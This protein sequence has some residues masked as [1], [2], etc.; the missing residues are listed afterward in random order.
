ME[1]ETPEI[2]MRDELLKKGKIPI[3]RM[4]E[5]SRQHGL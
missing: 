1:Y 5:I 2:I 3:D 4:L